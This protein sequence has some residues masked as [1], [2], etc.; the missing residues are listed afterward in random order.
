MHCQNNAAA[1][2]SDS[3]KGRA[4]QQSYAPMPASAITSQS[5]ARPSSRRRKSALAHC[6]ASTASISFFLSASRCARSAVLAGGR[7][8][9]SR[10]VRGADGGGGRTHWRADNGGRRDDG[11]TRAGTRDQA[12]DQ[13]EQ[14][15]I[16]VWESSL[17]DR[18]FRWALR[19]G[20]GH[21]AKGGGVLCIHF[22]AC[23]RLRYF[24]SRLI[25]DLK[26]LAF[27]DTRRAS[28]CTETGICASAVHSHQFLAR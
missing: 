8:M 9:R 25:R 2:V 26:T 28:V 23:S 18:P 16:W 15:P 3:R 10:G 20:R 14:E 6:S 19:T 11:G 7:R 4:R 27:V 5:S 22:V 1:R 17:V 24:V 21:G 13:A 12:L